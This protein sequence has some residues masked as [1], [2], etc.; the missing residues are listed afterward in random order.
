VDP[1]LSHLAV[2]EV[3]DSHNVPRVGLASALGC[4]S[5]ERNAVNIVREQVVR[6]DPE[7]SPS[8][9]APPLEEVNDIVL[10]AI[11]ACQG[12]PAANVID[13][14]IGE[15]TLCCLQISTGECSATSSP[16]TPFC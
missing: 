1:T 10:A 5:G 6:D 3:V 2:T 15:I 4:Y 13:D 7:R 14:L 12:I 16:W 9:L 11:V 8:S